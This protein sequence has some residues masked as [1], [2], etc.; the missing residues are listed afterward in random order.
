MPQVRTLNPAAGAY[1]L[2]PAAGAY[3]LNPAAGAYTLNPDAGA[4]TLNPAAGAY[5]LNPAASLFCMLQVVVEMVKSRLS[6]PD[7]QQQGW[8]LDGY[9]RSAS[10]AEAIEKENIRPDCFLLIDVSVVIRLVCKR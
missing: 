5:T 3:T 4:Y 2:N 7:V 10:Q 9:P 8:L 6:S 1:T